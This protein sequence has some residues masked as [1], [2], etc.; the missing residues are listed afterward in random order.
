MVFYI[1]HSSPPNS[2]RHDICE[3]DL[4]SISSYPFNF[5]PNTYAGKERESN[6]ED[7]RLNHD[8]RR[9]IHKVSTKA[10]IGE[11]RYEFKSFISNVVPW[12]KDDYT[13]KKQ[14]NCW[15]CNDYEQID[16]SIISK[17]LY[18]KS[19]FDLLSLDDAQN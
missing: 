3:D 13:D 19:N 15:I 4:V 18:G 10:T 14:F 6:L 11:E 9:T 5:Q 2:D 12:C 1:H 17:S 7:R 8:R 16:C